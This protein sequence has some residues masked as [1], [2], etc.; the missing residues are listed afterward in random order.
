MPSTLHA[1]FWALRSC[2]SSE[3]PSVTTRT[4]RRSNLG[5]GRIGY[6]FCIRVC[7]AS[8]KLE[9]LNGN[10]RWHLR[11]RR[12]RLFDVLKSGV[13]Q[14]LAF[15]RS[16]NPLRAFAGRPDRLGTW[17]VG[18]ASACQIS[19][20]P[21]LSPLEPERG[22]AF[23]GGRRGRPNFLPRPTGSLPISQPHGSSG[24]LGSRPQRKRRLT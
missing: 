5:R 9:C 16:P 3:W 2:T 21:A 12:I 1:S 24:R 20:A 22:S 18:E 15:W 23:P 11:G 7:G 4:L 19:S 17:L 10:L 13:T 8:L 14:R 6:Q